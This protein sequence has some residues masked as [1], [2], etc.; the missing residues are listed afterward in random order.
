MHKP[1]KAT[2]PLGLFVFILLVGGCRLTTKDPDLVYH[3]AFDD[4]S[5]KASAGNAADGKLLAGEIV[6]GKIGNALHV[7]AHNPGATVTIPNEFIGMAGCI[8]FWAKI[9]NGNGMC[10]HASFCPEFFSVYSEGDGRL[11]V[12]YCAN[13]GHGDSGLNFKFWGMAFN[14][15]Y[16]T[17]R[18][19]PYS[20]I[21]RADPAGWHHYALVW[22]AAGVKINLPESA[23]T[24]TAVLFLDG[25]PALHSGNATTFK[26]ESFL[27]GNAWYHQPFTL[28]FSAFPPSTTGYAIDEFKIWNT[29]K[30]DSHAAEAL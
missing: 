25:Q 18:T 27:K 30:L 16:K 13:Y 14:T 2:I 3:L 29:A 21:L 8:E 23:P 24:P 15:T 7:N 5:L 10:N 28:N 4:A 19:F 1:I 17:C 9:D 26:V 12:G 22:D 6:P 20:E 11:A